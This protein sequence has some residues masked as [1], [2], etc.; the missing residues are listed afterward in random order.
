MLSSMSLI[1]TTVR[2]SKVVRWGIRDTTSRKNGRDDS[3]GVNGGSQRPKFLTVDCMK[4]TAREGA[5]S[6]TSVF[7]FGRM[8]RL[9][10]VRATSSNAVGHMRGRPSAW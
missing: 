6:H 3:G 10:R 4:I 9:V 8:F 7:R 5:A 2:I 1:G